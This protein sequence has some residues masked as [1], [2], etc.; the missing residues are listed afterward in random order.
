MKKILII[1]REGQLGSTLTEQAENIQ[2][3]DFFH[4]T[5][6]T[7]DLMDASAISN[8]F[9]DKNFDFIINCAAYTAVDRAETDT[10]PAWRL[11]A[12][13]ANELAAEAA[14]MGAYFIHI[15]TDYVFGGTHFQPLKP[16]D[17]KTP[18]SVY[19]KSKLQGELDVLQQQPQSIIIRT[20]WLYSIYGKN[21]LKTMLQLGRERDSL[22]VV[23]DQV[24]TPTLAD[25]LANTI[26]T[27]IEKVVTDKKEFIPG[28][29]H[30]SNEGVC[31]WYDFTKA[32]FHETG[33]SCKVTPVES[34]QF[35]TPA[36]RPYF[37]VM[38]KSKIKQ[39]YDIE[40]T[41]WQ[42]SLRKC[43]RKL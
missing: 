38:D 33:I 26:L 43:L 8:Y 31:S 40:I 18:D 13:A 24:G 1:G 34:D 14:R 36:P 41:H 2:W 9:K 23:F 3:A 15:S 27:I 19:G 42:D 37:S 21:F 17:S 12:E 20:S 4:T 22:N 32:I 35:P 39:T 5:V 30:F 6:D 16:D 11:N 10:A 29:Y 28:V 25:D 7:L